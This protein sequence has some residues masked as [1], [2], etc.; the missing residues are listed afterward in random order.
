M[1]KELTWYEVIDLTSWVI[2]YP[3]DWYER[4]GHSH[5]L[6]EAPVFEHLGCYSSKKKAIER[7]KKWALDKGICYNRN[8]IRDLKKLQ[9]YPSYY[10]SDLV[11]MCTIITEV[12][13]WFDLHDEPAKDV[14]DRVY[15]TGAAVVKKTMELDKD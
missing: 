4:N 10:E 8:S 2:K 5:Y 3:T 7:L 9:S 11:V 15:G 12:G 14:W 1:A 13:I 6:R